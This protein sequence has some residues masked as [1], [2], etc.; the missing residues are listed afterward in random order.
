MFH[1]DSNQ[2]NPVRR[3]GLYR[4]WIRARERENAPLVCVW[5]DPSMAM[6]EPGANMRKPETAVARI[7]MQPAHVAD[8]REWTCEGCAIFDHPSFFTI[9]SSSVQARS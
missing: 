4:V 3:A 5:I 8:G 2:K 9:Y 1:I 6:F 7:E